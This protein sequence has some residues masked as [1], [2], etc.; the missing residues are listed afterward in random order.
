MRIALLGV[1]A[2][3]IISCPH[4]WTLN[5]AVNQ[6]R[7]PLKAGDLFVVTDH[8]NLSANSPGIGPNIDDYGPRF[9]D[10]TSMYHSELTSNLRN[11][12][13]DVSFSEG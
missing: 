12:C 8:A 11:L 5:N 13:S 7:Q 6:E 1:E 2:K 9:Y 4:V 3:T 10:I